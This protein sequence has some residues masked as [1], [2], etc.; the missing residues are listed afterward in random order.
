M[1]NK[2][3]S[4]YRRRNLIAWSF[5]APNFIGFA[6]FTLVPLVFSIVLS[7]AKWDASHPIEFVGLKNFV[8]VFKDE[9]FRVSLRNTICYTV[10]TV[11]STLVC[12]LALAVIL[13]RKGKII[14]F[15]RGVFF[16]PYV[17]SII[18]I[19]TVWN[20]LLLP[21]MGPIN[22]ILMS[23]GIKNPPGWFTSTD[24]ALITVAIVSVW[25][26]MGYYMIMYLGG[27][28]GIPEQLYEAAR[29]D[30]AS[31]RQQLFRITLPLL[32]PSHFLVSVMLIINCFKA[33]D[34]ILA[35]TNGGPGRSTNVLAYY[36]YN[37]AFV[38]WKFGEASVASCVLTVFVLVLTV[39]QFRFEKRLTDY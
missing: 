26:T 1:R 22:N 2:S 37:K 25:K 33:F 18:A 19:A 20:M 21:S 28:Q 29:M 36:V 34:L 13:N 10:I 15:A 38:G 9:T 7:F 27:L 8:N 4:Y 24:T 23:L 3:L 32:G 11:P 35:L 30:G 12:S 31:R 6:V 17:A 14:T 16:F 5:I 39:I